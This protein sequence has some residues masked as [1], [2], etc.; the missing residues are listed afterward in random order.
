MGVRDVIDQLGGQ[1]G[2]Q[3]T[4]QRHGQREGEDDPQGLQG[5][6]DIRDQQRGQ[7]IG[8]LALIADGRDRDRREDRDYGQHHDSHQRRGDDLGEFGEQEDDEQAGRRQR[9]DRPGH[10]GQMR[11]LRGEDQD[12]QSVDEPDH[13][14]ARDEPHQLG[15]A[16]QP[17]HHLDQSAQDHRGDQV[18][19]AVF[20]ADRGDDQ[21][22]GAGGRRDHGGPSAEEG[23]RHRHRE[24]GE[25]PHPR[26]HPG[27]DREGDGFRNQG[28]GHHQA[29]QRLRAEPARRLQGREDGMVSACFRRSGRLS[30]EA[31]PYP[32]VRVEFHSEDGGQ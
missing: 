12:R 26:V 30:H 9:V 3:Q 23:D 18:V 16:D 13:D 4:H 19:E 8:Q 1:Q 5:P 15:H 25:E 17:E 11:D 10:I 21:S 28:E 29:R 6:R 20:T 7:R 32:D 22:D 27:D 31:Q 24:G 14:R 2:L